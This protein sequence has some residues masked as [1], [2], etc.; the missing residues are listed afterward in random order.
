M[1]TSP[2]SHRCGPP[3]TSPLLSLASPRL[4][5]SHTPPILSPIFCRDEFVLDLARLPPLTSNLRLRDSPETNQWSH[6]TGDSIWSIPVPS[7][8]LGNVCTGHRRARRPRSPP[9]ADTAATFGRRRREATWHDRCRPSQDLRSPS[10]TPSPA[11]NSGRTR[12]GVRHSLWEAYCR[13]YVFNVTPFHFTQF[14]QKFQKS[15]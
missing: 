8:L 2:S 12:A 1:A 10:R 6:W 13:K 9:G 15:G 11:S 3:P 14:C 7:A 4:Q 5:E